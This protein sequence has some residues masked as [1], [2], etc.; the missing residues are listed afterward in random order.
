MTTY[1]IYNT[2]I[3]SPH[4]KNK[5]ARYYATV[6]FQ[7]PKSKIGLFTRQRN[8]LT[9]PPHLLVRVLLFIVS[10][11][12]TSPVN[13]R[14]EGPLLFQ[15]NSILWFLPSVNWPGFHKISMPLSSC[16]YQELFYFVGEM[17]PT[18]PGWLVKVLL[19]ITSIPQLIHQFWSSNTTSSRFLLLVWVNSNEK[20]GGFWIELLW[21]CIMILLFEYSFKLRFCSI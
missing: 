8:V 2:P 11:P 3:P 16:S 9:I 7:L 19:F 4:I 18:T 12:H 5:K 14:S 13:I 17:L 6:S 20:V 1:L 21:Q 15:I 10:T